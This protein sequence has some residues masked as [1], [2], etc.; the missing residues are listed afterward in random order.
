MNINDMRA[1]VRRD[2][3]DEDSENYRWSDDELNRHITHAVS[4]FS[5]AISL[6]Q[7]EV[8][9]TTTGSR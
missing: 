1:I 3:H 2:L 9:A 6:E 5:E 4:E 7:K 8:K